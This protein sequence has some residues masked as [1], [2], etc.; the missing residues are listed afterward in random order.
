[1][2][3]KQDGYGRVLGEGQQTLTF[4]G[5]AV[6]L[7]ERTAWSALRRRSAVQTLRERL[8]EW[9]DEAV[10][11][12]GRWLRPLLTAES[13]EKHL[14]SANAHFKPSGKCESSLGWA[15]LLY[16]LDIRPG[17]GTLAW[18]LPAT[19]LDPTKSGKLP[20]T[21]EGEALCHIINLYRTYSKPALRGFPGK[22]GNPLLRIGSR[23]SSENYAYACRFP[24]GT[25]S[26][27]GDGASHIGSFDCG[28]PEEPASTRV[29]FYHGSWIVQRENLLFAEEWIVA[30]YYNALYHGAS[31]SA[32]FLPAS[33]ASLQARVH[34]LVS[35]INL[36]HEA[37]PLVF[38]Q[39]WLDEA[40]NI[41][42]R[43]TTNGGADHGIIDDVVAAIAAKPHIA[44]VHSTWEATMSA[45]IREGCMFAGDAY[46]FVWSNRYK[47]EASLWGLMSQKTTDELPIV[48]GRYAQE[49]EGTW[50]HSL[51]KLGRDLNL[52]L[53][54]TSELKNLPC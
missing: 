30:K 22:T 40:S 43:A 41:K 1:M 11:E 45:I 46:H 20:L 42:R 2:G 34:T 29:P 35:F 25:L 47:S 51:T 33:S 12:K 9:V 28:A 39:A 36:L 38:T 21:I 23:P 17:R 50:K 49:P 32:I 5:A 37:G 53:D 7:Y 13:F 3:W 4:A 10:D 16:A 15:Q 18:R 8:G 31:D 14:V 6:D 44:T 19:A 54:S 27:K 26:L 52:L 48:L 24:F